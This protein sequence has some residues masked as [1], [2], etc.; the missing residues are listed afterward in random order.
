[1]NR[2]FVAQGAARARRLDR[3]HVAEN[4]GNGHVGR[5]QLFDEAQ[6][7]RQP[8]DGRGV[9]LLGDQIA[10]RAAQRRERIVMNFAAGD[11]RN[12]LVQ[13]V[14]QSAQDAALRLAPQAE[15]NKIVPRQKR[16]GDLR[17]NRFFVPV[18]ARKERLA[19]FELLQNVGA[20]LV[21][22]GAA[23]RSRRIA[24]KL[25]QFAERC[26]FGG[27]RGPLIDLHHHYMPHG[28]L[29]QNSDQAH[30]SAGFSLWVLVLA[31]T[32]PLRR[33][34]LRKKSVHHFVIPSE[35]GI[36]LRF[37]FKKRKRDFSMRPE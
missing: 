25:P 15:Q 21:F 2:E 8:R 6:I 35:R 32:N 10:A 11:V 30:G 28:E 4:V 22:H 26:R 12:F 1:M 18:N 34:W 9:A 33:N 3:V 31:R 7:A 37:R 20:K 36:P 23:R 17:Q 16:V 27:H 14:D 29:L 19:G 5:R 13:K 24:G